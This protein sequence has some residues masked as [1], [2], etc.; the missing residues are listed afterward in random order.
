MRPSWQPTAEHIRALSGGPVSGPTAFSTF[1]RSRNR[2]PPGCQVLRSLPGMGLILGARVLGEFGDDPA[3][4]VDAASRR[5]YAGSAPVTRASG[6]TTVVRL[7]RACNRRLADACRWWA[8][9]ATQNSPGARTFYLCRRITGDGHEASLR[10]LANNLLGQLSDQRLRA[11]SMNHP[12]HGLWPTGPCPA[13]RHE[14]TT[15]PGWSPHPGA[16]TG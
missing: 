4:F 6:R 5:A 8:F 14:R 10:W 11:D 3:R 13:R 9:T 16:A 2:T 1:L 15:D 7:R 12:A